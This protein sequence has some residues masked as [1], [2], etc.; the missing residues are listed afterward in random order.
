[1][2]GLC[3]IIALLSSRAA[4]QSPIETIEPDYSDEA[5]VAGLEGTVQIR[6]TVADDGTPR[7][8]EVARPLG[9]G[10]D[11]KALEAVKQ[12]RFRPVANQLLPLKIGVDFLLPDKQSRWHLTNV[13]FDLPEGATRPAF[14]S[15]KYPLGSGLALDVKPSA[16][17]E[18]RILAVVGRQAWAIVFFDVDEKGVPRNFEAPNVSADVW[19]NQAIALVRSWCF[20][21]GMKDGKPIQVRCTLSLV[22]GKRNLSAAELAQAVYLQEPE[23]PAPGPSQ[24]HP[25]APGVARVAVSASM[26]A[27]RLIHGVA[28]EFSPAAWQTGLGGKIY[29]EVLIATD[30]H[31][32]EALPVIRRSEFIPLVTKALKQWVYQPTTVNGIPAEVTTMVS[33]EVPLHEAK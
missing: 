32:Q 3:L 26:Q 28:P 8:L 19:R 29:F 9:L 12:W 4:A 33:I 7:N 13:A 22:W 18:A 2:R 20:T 16:I 1:M 10:L 6:V 23:E 5:R 30:G 14:L 25:P 27:A 15:A 17:D 21:P 11:E 24:F 31:V